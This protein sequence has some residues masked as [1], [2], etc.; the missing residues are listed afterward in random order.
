MDNKYLEFREKVVQGRKTPIIQIYS[1]NHGD[2]LGEIKWFGR[3]RQYTFFPCSDTIWNVDC[4]NT[5]N[6]K[7]IE[8][9]GYRKRI[10]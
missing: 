7:I 10:S 1:K 5:M 2:L 9:I 4:L 3:W 8:L 6:A